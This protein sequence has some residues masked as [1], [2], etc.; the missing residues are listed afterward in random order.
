MDAET[1][2]WDG[3]ER[4]PERGR[5][6][7]G[8][9]NA[10][11]GRPALSS[12]ALAQG[13]GTG[14]TA[15]AAP[16]TWEVQ[17]GG[18]GSGPAGAPPVYEAQAYGP[19]PA[20]IRAGDTVTWKFAGV[21]T[22]TF[23]S[24]KPDLPLIVPGPGGPS[25]GEL[26][27][28]PGAFPMGMN[29]RTPIVYDGTQQISSG[30]PLQGPPEEAYFAVTFTRPGLYGYICVLHPGMRAEVEVR[31][32]TASLPE[33][34]AQAKARGQATLSVLAAK[35]QQ[36]AAHVRPV[37]AGSV[38]TAL[39]GLGDGFGASALQF[40]NGDKTVK[41]GDTV[42]WANADPFEIHTVTFTGGARDPEFIEP[43]P[44]A[45]GPPA[46]VIPANVAGPVGGE[47]YSGQGYANSGILGSG[48]TYA[49]R[50]D[51]PAG[52]YEYLCII[53]PW[54]RGTITVGG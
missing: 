39:A 16:Q 18:G 52:A 46:L 22:V 30:A 12:T 43:H 29:G 21:H 35:V 45:G 28:G 5:G 49:L 48:G 50:F 44:Q 10:A 38:H 9:E 4:V 51:A 27:L 26:Q 20:I 33:T 6:E 53:H 37:I 25:S 47:S 3:A 34:P 54:M 7:N 42:V 11:T 8:R 40:I 14:G 19:G 17:V 2:G 1:R 23:N 15:A 24:G 32:A 36:D 13:P 41:R 31:E